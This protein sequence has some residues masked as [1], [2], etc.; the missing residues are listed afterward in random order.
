M[1]IQDN[2]TTDHTSREFSQINKTVIQT[3]PLSLRTQFS[4]V[5]Y[6]YQIKYYSFCPDGRYL[7]TSA[8]ITRQPPGINNRQPDIL[9]ADLCGY[10]QGQGFL[11]RLFYGICMCGKQCIV[12]TV[13]P[14]DRVRVNWVGVQIVFTQ[15]HYYFSIGTL[16]IWKFYFYYYNVFFFNDIW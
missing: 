7:A 4:W 13:R 1:K 12:G 2:I 10:P 14:F 3:Y 9:L 5:H 8:V 15:E 6:S 16:F 11:L